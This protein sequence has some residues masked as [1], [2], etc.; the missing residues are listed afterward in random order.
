M[1][2]APCAIWLPI[3]SAVVPAVPAVSPPPPVNVIWASV[4]ARLP[5]VCTALET[6]GAFGAGWKTG[7]SCTSGSTIERNQASLAAVVCLPVIRL[8]A[9]S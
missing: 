9:L 8:A 6:N 5:T 2:L 4:P 7:A 1:A 3:T